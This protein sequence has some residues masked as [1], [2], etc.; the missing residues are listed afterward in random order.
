MYNQT[1]LPASTAE[2]LISTW[3]KAR[4][5]NGYFISFYFWLDGG[6]CLSCRSISRERLMLSK[7]NH[8]SNS[9]TIA[10]SRKPSIFFWLP[11]IFLNAA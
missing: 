1:F 3:C 5:L 10:I 9:I 11:V 7:S 6:S 8:S 4:H 2:L